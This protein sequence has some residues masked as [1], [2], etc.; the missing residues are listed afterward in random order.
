[1][2]DR[3]VVDASVAVKW[4]VEE[5][6][7]PIARA[8]AASWVSAGVTPTAPYLMPAEVANALHRRVVD[9]QLS[10]G[11]ASE[12]IETLLVSGVELLET[13]ALHSRAIE[14]ASL[15]EQ[16]AVYDVHYLALAETL[17]CDLWTADRRFQRA[18]GTTS[19]RVRWIGEATT[20][21]AL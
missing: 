2:S 8:L 16:G 3:V 13:R 1:M 18:V 10:L 20:A 21:D 14:L 11:R 6:D 4:L 12:L 17:E 9:S 7:T 5:A 19:D 15:L